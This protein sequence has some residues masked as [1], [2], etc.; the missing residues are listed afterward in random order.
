[1]EGSSLVDRLQVVDNGDIL[2]V[3]GGVL[4]LLAGPDEGL[5]K[6]ENALDHGNGYN[7]H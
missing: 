2:V 7:N 3:E 1:V 4:S 5:L 6:E